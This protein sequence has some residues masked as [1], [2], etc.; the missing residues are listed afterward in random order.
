MSRLSVKTLASFAA[1]R[2]SSLAEG[3]TGG[4]G[5]KRVDAVVVAREEAAEKPVLSDPA[6]Q[7]DEDDESFAAASFASPASFF[8]L[9]FSSY[10]A[11]TLSISV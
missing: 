2:A 7:P 5:G 9:A 1:A 6:I 10:S 11:L 8:R 3:V 4:G